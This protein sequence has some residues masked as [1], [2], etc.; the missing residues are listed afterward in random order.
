MLQFFMIY[1]NDTIKKF[2]FRLEKS[3]NLAGSIESSTI[4]V[5]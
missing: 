2:S 1:S 3:L 4:C 5:T